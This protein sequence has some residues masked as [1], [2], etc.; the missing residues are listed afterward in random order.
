MSIHA[1]STV[2][3]AVRCTTATGDAC[4][5]GAQC[6]AGCAPPLPNRPSDELV[7]QHL[8]A[9]VM[10]CWAELP[11]GARDRILRQADDVLGFAPIPRIRNEIVG[12]MLRRAKVQWTAALRSVRNIGSPDRS[13]P[14]G[15]N[16]PPIG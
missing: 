1:I 15:P 13:L 11:L 4:P 3:D 6:P 14:I 7:L 9:A 2:E 5:L 12:L 16:R 8:G 10:L